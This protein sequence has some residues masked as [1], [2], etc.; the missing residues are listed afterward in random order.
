MVGLAATM[1]AASEFV[2]RR[3][4]IIVIGEEPEF[5]PVDTIAI[6]QRELEIVGSR[7]GGL[8]DAVDALEMMAAGIIQPRIDRRFPLE[9]LPEAME[10]VR[11]GQTHGRVVIDVKE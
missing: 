1:K 7:N 6:A 3:G 10:Y 4:R 2:G 5:P 11:S 9:E 8:Q